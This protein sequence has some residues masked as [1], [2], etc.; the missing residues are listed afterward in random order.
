MYFVSS[1]QI[2]TKINSLSVMIILKNNYML[3]GKYIFVIFLS[4]FA[5]AN[6]RG[7]G[8]GS[9][10]K[11]PRILKLNIFLRNVSQKYCFLCFK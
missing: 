3:V 7:M 11:A 2:S 1:S 4:L 10:A 5:K 9:G 6:F 8:I